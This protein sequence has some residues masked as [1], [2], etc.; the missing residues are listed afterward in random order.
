MPQE[1]EIGHQ[2]TQ[3][4]LEWQDFKWQVFI[5]FN[6]IQ[7]QAVNEIPQIKKKKTCILSPKQIQQKTKFDGL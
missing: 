7:N 3:A 6:I 5:L 4:I 1:T 2:V